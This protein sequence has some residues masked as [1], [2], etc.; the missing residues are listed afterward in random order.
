MALPPQPFGSLMGPA[1][2]P[3]Q[4]DPTLGVEVPLSGPMDF[5]GGAEVIETPEGATVQ[6]LALQELLQAEVEQIPFDANLAEYIDDAELGA[7]ASDLVAAYEDDLGSRQEWEETYVKGLDL[8]GVKP[9]EERSSPFEGASAVTHPLIAESVVQFQSQAYK[10]ILPAGGPVRTKINGADTPEKQEQAARVKNYMNHLIMDEMEEYDPDTDQLLFYLPLS[11]ST[12]K[13][14]YY[15]PELQR[16]VS[17]FVP[18]QDVVVPY[19][20]SDLRTAARITHVLKMQDNDVRKRQVMG[21]YRDVDLAKA[22]A[23]LP[24]TIREKVD[25]IQGSRPSYTDDTRTILEMHV[26]LDLEDFPDVDQFGEPT[27]IKLPYIVAVDESSSTVLSIR[28]NYREDDLRRLPIEYFTHYKFLPGLGFYGFGLTHM[29]GGLGR[30]TTSLLRQLIDAGTLSNLPAGFKARG[31]RVTNHDQPLQPGEWRDIDTPGGNLRDALL[32]LPYKEPSATLAQLLG[33]LVTEGRRFVSIA[34]EQMQGMNQEMPVGTAVAMLE[35]GTKV[36]SAIHKRLHYAQKREFRILARVIGEHLPLSYPY[37][38]PGDAQNL[39]QQD[40]SG[41]VDILP[42]SDPNI[43]SMAQRVAL[44]Q[45]QLRLAQS[46]PQMHNLHAAYRR[47]YQALEIQNID[48]ILPPPQQPQPMD[49]AMENGRALVG[50][51]LQAFEDQ[52]HEAHIMA[53]IAVL[54]VPIYMATPHAITALHAHIQEHVA[55]LTRKQVLEQYAEM[56][57]QA[58]IA[59]QTGS[60]NPQDGQRQLQEIDQVMADPQHL[61]DYVALLQQ[62]VLEQ[63]MPQLMPPQADPS[64]DPLVQIRQAEVALRA[65]KQQQDAV[66]TERRDQIEQQRLQQ[67]A[68]TDLARMDLQESI[69][70]ERA[71][72]NRERIAASLKMANMRL[73]GA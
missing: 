31:V 18:A 56:K 62:Q 8:L 46:N 45:E 33:L 25:E 69:A 57:Q 72:V 19:S 23:N 13:K 61:A 28:R 48:E 55:L 64:A 37:E 38:L 51:P 12:F 24:D 47:M 21:E 7:L 39:K 49:P 53:H 30:A 42:V 40:F 32:P 50:T 27:G 34:D 22:G 59:M 41:S 2:S 11:G 5:E 4:V 54:G 70:D 35:R 44:A 10:E 29:L 20:A 58:L 9:E 68:A 73:G 43:F 17:R 63:L 14:I 36:L 65:E 52:N 71:R 1:M 67:R 60:M 26:L 3:D 15:D 16:P 66:K 6:A